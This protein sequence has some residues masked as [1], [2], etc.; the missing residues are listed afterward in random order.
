MQPA[1]PGRN[2]S[3]TTPEDGCGVPPRPCLTFSPPC[4]ACRCSAAV[5]G[6]RWAGGWPGG[7]CGARGAPWPLAAP[8]LPGQSIPSLSPAGMSIH[9]SRCRAQ[10]PRASSPRGFSPSSRSVSRHG[11]VSRAVPSLPTRRLPPS[12]WLTLPVTAVTP[13]PSSQLPPRGDGIPMRLTELQARRRPLL[14]EQHGGDPRVCREQGGQLSPTPCRQ[15][16]ETPPARDSQRG[17]GQNCHRHMQPLGPPAG[18]PVACPLGDTSEATSIPSGPC[19]PKPASPQHDQHH[20][21]ALGQRPTDPIDP[22]L[23]SQKAPKSPS[24]PSRRQLSRGG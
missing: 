11:D 16:A 10:E 4:N 21:G 12:P 15:G 14:T 3:P 22:P 2:P 20:E 17:E 9:P 1:L 7:Q 18:P 5:G 6:W 24:P 8:Q 13:F 23:Q 19:T